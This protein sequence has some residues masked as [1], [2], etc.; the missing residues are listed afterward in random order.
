MADRTH[1]IE[2]PQGYRVRF[3]HTSEGKL[4]LSIISPSSLMLDMQVMTHD[5]IEQLD[6]FFNGR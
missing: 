5:E 2:T 1:E 6:K 4:I 3:D